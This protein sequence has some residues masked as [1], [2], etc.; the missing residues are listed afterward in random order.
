MTASIRPE[1]FARF[2]NDPDALE[3]ARWHVQQSIDVL[4][5]AIAMPAATPEMQN[6][7]RFALD[8][9]RKQ[10]IGVPGEIG[11]PGTVVGR[12]DE[13]F[14]AKPEGEASAPADAPRDPLELVDLARLKVA[15]GDKVL[16][17]PHDCTGIAT[18]DQAEE[19][20][21]YLREDLGPHFPGVQF[22]VLPL[23]AE[24]AV[25]EGGGDG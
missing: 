16:V 10:F 4:A 1:L 6:V 21:R 18:P 3:W 22:F 12:F 17:R 8:W 14:G 5:E 23:H 25:I 24:V 9:M 19:W 11:Q 15:P 20:A 2:G 13:R 7:G